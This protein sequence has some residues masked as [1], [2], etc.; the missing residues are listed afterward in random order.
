MKI[1]KLVVS[2]VCMSMIVFNFSICVDAKKTDS[3]DQQITLG[4]KKIYMG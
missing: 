1:K 4:A 3:T 2:F